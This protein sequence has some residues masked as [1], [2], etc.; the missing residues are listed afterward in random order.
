[1]EIATI[2]F[3]Q[4][5]AEH[6]FGRLR[7]A[8]IRRLVD[9]RRHN[10][11][12]LAGFSKGPDLRYF[13]QEICGADYEHDLRLAPTDELLTAYRKRSID[14]E[15]YGDQFV[16]LMTERGIP[17]SLQRAEFAQKTALLCSEA[18]PSRCHRRLVA[19]LLAQ[20]WDADIQHL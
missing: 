8:G 14:W 7:S 18:E 10:V 16:E 2:G 19:E 3:T 6:F 9:V 15:T 13:L 20:A 17:G 5:S 1:M 12:Q 4:S 11:S